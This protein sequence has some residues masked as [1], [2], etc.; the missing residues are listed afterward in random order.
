MDVK[1]LI[2]GTLSPSKDDLWAL[3]YTI[4]NGACQSGTV[5]LRQE[6]DRCVERGR[7][8]SLWKLFRETTKTFLDV[9]FGMIP[10]SINQN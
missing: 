9:K 8:G 3:L 6:T 2:Q 5:R 10:D 7:G 4:T 1:S